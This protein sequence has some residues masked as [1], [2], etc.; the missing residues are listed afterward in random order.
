[1]YISYQWVV[2]TGG[3]FLPLDRSY[4]W[5]VLTSLIPL[6]RTKGLTTIKEATFQKCTSLVN[7]NLDNLTELRTIEGNAFYGCELLALMRLLE[8]LVQIFPLGFVGHGRRVI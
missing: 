8:Y 2:L 3:P 5:T 4:R 6:C 1:M 7:M